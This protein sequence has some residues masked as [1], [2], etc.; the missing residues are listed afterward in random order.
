[1]EEA[2]SILWKYAR[3]E[4]IE[5]N[6][7]TVVATISQSIAAIRLIM[8][9]EGWLQKL[10]DRPAPAQP[11]SPQ[12]PQSPIDT[13]A[14]L[15]TSSPWKKKEKPFQQELNHTI[16]KPSYHTTKPRKVC[17]QRPC[18][19]NANRNCNQATKPRKVCCPC[20]Y[21]TAHLY[22]DTTLI[23]SPMIRHYAADRYH[24]DYGKLLISSRP[25][26]IISEKW[27]VK[28]EKWKHEAIYS[29]TEVVCEKL[30][31]AGVGANGN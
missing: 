20:P 16:I 26:P 28:S 7:K 25:P 23:G 22:K 18:V 31:W 13:P 1:M 10:E 9:L 24:N 27:K 29:Q 12:S 8:R 6:G 3:R 21:I 14:F 15:V 5:S 17:R 30:A 11:Q 4:A 19:K 2:L